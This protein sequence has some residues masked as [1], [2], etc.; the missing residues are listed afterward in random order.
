MDKDFSSDFY[1]RILNRINSNIFITDIETDK[2]VFMNDFMKKTFGLKK[3]EGQICWKLLQKDRSERCE[4]CKIDRLCG[5]DENGISWKESNAVTGRTYLNFDMLQE[6]NGR[7]YHIQNSID[8]TNQLKLMS[9]AS[10]DAL[11]GLMNRSAGLA[12]LEDV[13]STVIPG[14]NA[15]VA[16]CDIN[17]LKK[18]NDRY[19][20]LEG[21]RLL[22][23]S[24]A[25]ISDAVAGLGSAFRLSG[26]EFVVVFDGL[27]SA[28]AESVM[29]KILDLMAVSA[30][31]NGLP[32]KMSFSYG[33]ADMDPTD[34]L[35]GHDVLSVADARMYIS[36]REYHHSV[37]DQQAEKNDFRYNKELLFDVLSES[38]DDYIF[39][40][41]LKT[42][43]SLLSAKMAEDFGLSSQV[44]TDALEFWTSRVHPDD[45]EKYLEQKRAIT[46]GE[47]DIPATEYRAKNAKGEWVKLLRRGKMI[48]DEAGN[49]DLFAGTVRDMD[50]SEAQK[51]DELRFISENNTG[52]VFKTKLSKGAPIIY[53]N[54]AFYK[55]NGYEKS[56]FQKEL[57]GSTSQLIYSED[58][59]KIERQIQKAIEENRKRVVLECRIHR[60]GGEPAW[61]HMDAGISTLED[62]T[63]VMTGMIMDITKRRELEDSLRRTRKMFNIAREHTRLN[64]W[65]YDIEHSRVVL[66]PLPNDENAQERIIE[67]VPEGLI[68]SGYVHPASV[69]IYRKLYEKAAKGEEGASAVIRS[70]IIGSEEKYCWE[71]LTFVQTQYSDGKPV[72]ALGISE[73]ITAQKE[74]EI[75]RF[76]ENSMREMLSED[77]IFSFQFNLERNVT[78]NV[79]VYSDSLDNVISPH[80]EYKDAYGAVY[81]LIVGKDER[82]KFQERCTLE[83]IKEYAESGQEI[84]DFEF[85][86]R[87]KDGKI[88]W[89]RLSLKVATRPE[90]DTV[91]FGYARNIDI[92]K[93]RELALRRKAEIDELSCFYNNSTAKLIID[94][95]ISKSLEPGESR[96]MVLLDTDNFKEANQIGGFR[97]GD[98]ILKQICE[99]IKDRIPASCVTARINADLIMLFYYGAGEQEIRSAAEK[100][101]KELCG[102]YTVK[103]HSVRLTVSAG[104]VFQRTDTEES[105]DRLYQCA[106]Y[107]LERAKSEGKNRMLEY[108]P[109]TCCDSEAEIFVDP[110]SYEVIGMNK[111]GQIDFGID[112]SCKGKPCYEVLRGRNK[113]CPF[114]EDITDLNSV[115]ERTYFMPKLNRQLNARRRAILIDGKK[116]WQIR[117]SEPDPSS[118]DIHA[119][120]EAGRIMDICWTKY[121]N[122]NSWRSIAKALT[123]QLLSVCHA[124]RVTYLDM[125]DSGSPIPIASKSSSG[126]DERPEEHFGDPDCL[127]EFIAKHA[128]DR[129]IVINSADENFQKL[130]EYFGGDTKL[131]MVI[132]ACFNGG[133][134]AGCIAAEGV[135]N[136]NTAQADLELLS[137]FLCRMKNLFSLQKDNEFL[138]THDH[139]TGL[140]NYDSFIG[141]LKNV[142]SDLFTS[143]GMVGVHLAGLKE[144]N[145]KYG[146]AGGDE[147]LSFTAE[148][149]ARLYG[150]ENC[151]RVSGTKIYVFCPDVTLDSFNAKTDKL[152]DMIAKTYP[153]SIT[154]VSVWEQHIIHVSQL[155]RQIDEKMRLA[156]EK[157]NILKGVDK[158]AVKVLKG[159]LEKG[160]SQ[161]CLRTYLQPKA[162]TETMEIIGAEAL[163]RYCDSEKGILAPSK[164]L[165]E[166]ERAGLVRR[167]DLFVLESVCRMISEWSKKGW[168][169]FPISVNYS[170]STI[171]EP[172]ILEE[173]NRIT[174]SY[175][176]NKQLIEIEITETI[177]SI[178]SA[179][180]A[181]T[182]SGFVKA[183]YNIALDDFGTE[184]SN[185][186]VLYSLNLQTLKLDRSIVS[187]IYHDSRAASVVKNVINICRDLDISCVAE[188]VETAEQLGVLK[189]LSCD[190]IQ[191]YYLNKPLPE[192][193][194]ADRYVY[195]M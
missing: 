27:C 55:I 73:D 187:D 183:G 115:C 48:C 8:I 170:R 125:N 51:R 163:I 192:E 47:S 124:D 9:A 162:N 42:G 144:Y 2:I 88:V 15:C 77:L 17:G 68:N 189:N 56:Q 193:D 107:A 26:D 102:E 178:D 94:D 76:R 80:S 3:P 31:E 74:A 172:G 157:H 111:I 141:Y 166:I 85:R 133:S 21:D 150:S 185:I 151:Y 67:N 105:Y 143:F 156:A 59:K 171:L 165:P 134:V 159:E 104:I 30:E 101:R 7:T 120:A 84:P 180:L 148:A 45:I 60:R 40:T 175:G 19:G 97:T 50:S 119:S 13:A 6:F 136:I 174:E 100:L 87:Q 38:T 5:C 64:M 137:G 106:T 108:D 110:A 37:G 81:K 116:I 44:I 160:F 195:R 24:A 177:G 46:D 123:S 149:A 63:K 135:E 131:P 169:P 138:I 12:L 181:E 95:I 158:A 72:W 41:N 109:E 132:T 86:C 33:L 129:T 126:Q 20:H 154:A 69:E 173:T 79:T 78:E 57:N 186:H 113:P 118:S 145:K 128:P 53:A 28:D 75:K 36:K 179:T 142:N 16:L 82:K 34:G 96:A 121:Q 18:V 147:M 29:K 89:A 152:R 11:T 114:C 176:V 92:A 139:K 4:S 83:K 130:R 35:S 70:R 91:L 146:V 66:A 1:R 49:P 22:S 140:L 161:N 164:F 153:D 54:D 52:G 58:L 25:C 93:K 10:T 190:E 99:L 167:I 182:V 65:E 43:R 188:G 61:I 14:Q 98:L 32:Y 117:M 194:F 112:K 155:K 23:L 62:G 191:G 39:V 168:K 90:G 122:G 127:S 71:K 184:Y 103:K